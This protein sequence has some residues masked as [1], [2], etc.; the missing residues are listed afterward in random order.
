[1][2]EHDAKYEGI[3]AGT[4]L[5]ISEPGANT[6]VTVTAIRDMFTGTGDKLADVCLLHLQDVGDLAVGVIERFTQNMESNSLPSRTYG[7][8]PISRGKCLVFLYAPLVRI[9]RV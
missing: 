3:A 2:I 8:N 7:E 1:M 4:Q 6:L 5:L 9:K